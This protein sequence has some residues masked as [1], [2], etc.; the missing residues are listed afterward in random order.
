MRDKPKDATH[1]NC[2]TGRFYKESGGVVYAWSNADK[3]I[4]SVGKS[5][6]EFTP[7]MNRLETTNDQ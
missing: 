3:W 1:Q 2:I 4:E 5:L 7:F 6:G